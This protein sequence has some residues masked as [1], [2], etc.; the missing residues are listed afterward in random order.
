MAIVMLVVVAGARIVNEI[1][2]FKE[3]PPQQILSAA[4]V[5]NSEAPSVAA[6]L[7][8]KGLASGAPIFVRI[9]K[10][11]KELVLWVETA[12]GK[13]EILKIYPI[14]TYSGELGPKLREGDLQSPEG[15]Y[16][17]RKEALLP[18]SQFHRAFNI[19]FPNAFDRAYGRTGSFLMVHGSCVSVGC[20]A[21]TN[22]GIREIYDLAEAALDND[23]DFFRV[24]IFPF[25]M[26]DENLSRFEGNANLEFWKNLKEG[27]DLFETDKRPPDVRVSEKKYVFSSD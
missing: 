24:H 7:G 4:L 18:T 22:S 2:L 15:F 26:N 27:Y 10:E 13:Y 19:G 1:G 25:R 16:F 9:F 21:M 3:L 6:L 23:Q 14:C 20:Y 17:V 11:P 5:P 8:Q 12:T